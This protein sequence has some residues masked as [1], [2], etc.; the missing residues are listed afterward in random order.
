MF[1]G[2]KHKVIL[3]LIGDDLSTVELKRTIH[4]HVGGQFSMC[5]TTDPV[6]VAQGANS[7]IRTLRDV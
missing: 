3:P 2:E 6:A 7:D 1:Y 4:A 5:F